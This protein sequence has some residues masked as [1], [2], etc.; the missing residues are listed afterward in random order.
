MAVLISERVLIVD[1]HEG[2]ASVLK[3]VLSRRGHV[4]EQATTSAKAVRL[5][6]EFR[7]T[8]VLL[9]WALRKE[10]GKGL[11]ARLRRCSNESGEALVIVVLSYANMPPN[12]FLDEDVDDYLVKPELLT[13]IERRFGERLRENRR[14]DI[15]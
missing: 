14:I 5:I 10:D 6:R 13:E 4:C 11:A 9:E 1:D 7:P 8:V 3:M 12:F 15:V 2:S